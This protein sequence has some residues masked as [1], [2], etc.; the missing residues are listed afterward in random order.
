MDENSKKQIL[1]IIN[2]IP[3]NGEGSLISFIEKNE[4][5]LE[6]MKEAGLEPSKIAEIDS[7]AAAAI[8]AEAAATAAAAAAIDKEAEY[9]NI[10]DGK[11]SIGQIKKLIDDGSLTK[12]DLLN[13]VGM[14]ED[15]YNRIK[16]YYKRPTEFHDWESIPPITKERTDIYF[17][18]QPG[19]GK[20]CILA[21]LFHH[22]NED[23]LIIENQI[24]PVGNA[25]RFQL[26]EE[27]QFG[28]LPDSTI[29]DAD[30]GVNYIPIDLA[31]E[32]DENGVVKNVH[33]LNFV[34]MSGEFFNDT[35]DPKKGL[36]S[37]NAKGFLGNDNKKLI[38][39]VLDY[40]Q[41][42]ERAQG[43]I[44][45]ASQGSKFQNS[46]ALL[47]AFGTLAKTD[48][49]YILISKSDLFPKG[50]DKNEFAKEFL[51]NNYKG[52]YNNCKMLQNKYKNSFN[53][54]LFP[55]SLGDVIYK[56]LLTRF[57]HEPPNDLLQFIC[58]NSFVKSKSNSW[59]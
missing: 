54:T 29:A 10:K 4:I 53:L 6:E 13:Q 15:H 14:E 47:D 48:G 49:I 9:Q 51:K 46:L 3:V 30:K 33:P 12:E 8:S 34:E 56:N 43:G 42:M 28:V 27:I 17:L 37:I 23:G 18:G 5:T 19:S 38:F 45:S 16:N 22:A 26:A 32:I 50:V 41:H 25:Y 58:D 44:G 39:F 20:S 36:T 35:L 24:N 7:L 59:F 11:Y 40:D 52:F 57:D 1:Q 2:E 21:S 55:Y 31:E